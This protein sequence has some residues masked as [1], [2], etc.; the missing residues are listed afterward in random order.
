VQDKR[1]KLQFLWPIRT[2]GAETVA[3]E[4][5]AKTGILDEEE[6]NL[7]VYGKSCDIYVEG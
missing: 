2:N 6:I 1:L 5:N 3:E 7:R 4:E